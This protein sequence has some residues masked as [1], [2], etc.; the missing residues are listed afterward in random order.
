M[1]QLIY[2]S[3]TPDPLDKAELDS[4]LETSRKNNSESGITGILL[5]KQLLFLQVLEGAEDAVMATFKRI[6][7]DPRHK[8][9]ELVQT[10]DV[11]ER[12][13]ESWEMAFRQIDS[14]SIEDKVEQSKQLDAIHE[15]VDPI[16][17][18]Q[19]RDYLNGFIGLLY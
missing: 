2:T 14:T 9:V 3:F 5:Y 17:N 15:V 10:I 11:D 19:T 18:Q 4:L 8:D 6:A 12:D 7:N 13:F 16:K 1:I